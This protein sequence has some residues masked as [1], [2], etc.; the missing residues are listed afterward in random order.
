MLVFYLLSSQLL[1]E[2]IISYQVNQ[3]I[4]WFQK[5]MFVQTQLTGYADDTM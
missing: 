3:G 1:I 5:K 4:V 2:P